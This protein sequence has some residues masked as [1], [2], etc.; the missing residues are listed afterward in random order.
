MKYSPVLT[1]NKNV[2]CKNKAHRWR[3]FNDVT[4][5]IELMNTTEMVLQTKATVKMIV[6]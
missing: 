4:V 2:S 6:S 3:I 5:L 1:I